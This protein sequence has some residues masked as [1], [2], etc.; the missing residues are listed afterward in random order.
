MKN[1]TFS[2]LM[3]FCINAFTQPC[4]PPTVFV[5]HGIVCPGQCFMLLASASGTGN[6]FKWSNGATTDTT[7]VCPDSTT[8]YTVTVKDSC[9]DSVVVRTNLTV[10]PPL[11]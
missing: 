4:T 1:L 5:N 2:L 3:L 11:L 7:K 6:S 9:G 10:Y 8:T